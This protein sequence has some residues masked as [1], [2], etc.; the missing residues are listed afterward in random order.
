MKAVKR[1]LKERR[2]CVLDFL[3]AGA[4]ASYIGS[5]RRRIAAGS[6]Q[7]GAIIRTSD[8]SKLS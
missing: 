2:I 5:G 8:Q 6:P 4:I 3:Y 7:P 1:R